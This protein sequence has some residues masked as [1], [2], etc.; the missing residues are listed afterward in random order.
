MLGIEVHLQDA[1]PL[2]ASIGKAPAG[3]IPDVMAPSEQSK[4]WNVLARV[5]NW[6]PESMLA[7][8]EAAVASGMRTINPPSS[9]R[10]GRDHWLSLESAYRGG[11]AIPQSLVGMDPEETAQGGAEI[12]GFP[13]VVKLRRSRMGVGVMRA[14][15]H[16]HL[17]A[18]LDSLWRLG[19][20]FI[21]QEFIPPGGHSVR[22]LVLRNSVIAA[23]R[24]QASSGEWRSN[25]ARGGKAQGWGPPEEAVMIAVEAA[26]CLGLGLAG[27]DLLEGPD[28][29]ILC[30][31]NPTPGF[32]HLEEAT[33]VDIASAIVRAAVE[34]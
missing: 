14:E 30:E 24:F 34:S 20:E 3:L 21:L 18:I 1:V 32:L 33:G 12:L 15:S 17:Q 7:L 5:G 27:V 31:I 6:R 10:R 11:L 23:A 19:E 25:G 4:D 2:L 16:D 13:L 8:L 9:I 28:G 26:K 29:L 22:L